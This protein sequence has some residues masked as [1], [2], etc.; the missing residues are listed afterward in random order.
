MI[1]NENIDLELSQALFHQREH[2][3]QHLPYNYELSVYS[4]IKNGKIELVK[5]IMIPLNSEGLGHLSD[6]SLRNMKYH[7]IVS[8]ALITRFCMEGGMDEET[9]YTLS[10]LYIQRTDLCGNCDQVTGLHNKMIFD[11]TKRMQKLYMERIVSQ[12]VQLSMGFIRRNLHSQI[13]ISGIGNYVHLNP[14]YLC[15]LFKKEVG[16]TISQYIRRERVATAKDLLRYSEY[17]FVEIGNFLAFNSQSHFISMFKSETK[18]TPMQYRRKYYGT[19][20][21]E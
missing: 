14:N 3:I 18:M 15:A 7:L 6:D 10:D 21:S 1:R 13:S 12:K 2:K 9:A 4:A 11:Y 19:N 20:W 17:S 8:I 16:I 5:Q